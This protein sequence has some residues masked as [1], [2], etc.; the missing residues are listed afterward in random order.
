MSGLNSGKHIGSSEGFNSPYSGFGGPIGGGVFNLSNAIHEWNVV[1]AS[2][3][4]STIT[5][6]D[7]GS[8]GGLPLTNPT[9]GQLPFI[10][11]IDGKQAIIGDASSDI[12]SDIAVSEF[13]GSDTS[14]V[15]HF[16]FRAPSAWGTSQIYCSVSKTAATTDRFLLSTT[17]SGE[18]RLTVSSG[19]VDT[20]LTGGT[21]MSTSTN[22]IMSIYSTGALLKGY[23]GTTL[24]FNNAGTSGIRW[25]ADIAGTTTGFELLGREIGGASYTDAHQAYVCYTP[26]VSDAA[27]LVDQATIAANWGITV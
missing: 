6:P 21:T 26:F 5:L 9:A 7:T 27:V 12:V 13:R 4:G 18:P 23:L 8:I 3:V 10:F 25:F 16:V 24:Q 20:L 17:T 19:G 14:G 1:N 2:V 11:P 22:Y 15:M